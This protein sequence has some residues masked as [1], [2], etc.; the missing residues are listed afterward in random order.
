MNA[1]TDRAAK[2]SNEQTTTKNQLKLAAVTIHTL[3]NTVSYVS[4][5]TQIL[6]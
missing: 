4:S 5:K 1:V 3:F 6:W 2:H